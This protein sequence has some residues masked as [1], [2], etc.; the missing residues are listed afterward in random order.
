MADQLPSA[1]GFDG[2]PASSDAADRQDACARQRA[3]RQ[4]HFIGPPSRAQ[5]RHQFQG[6]VAQGQRPVGAVRTEQARQ[7]PAHQDAAQDVRPRLPQCAERGG[8]DLG[9]VCAPWYG[10][11]ELGYVAG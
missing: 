1:L 4:P 3:H 2:A 6:P 9:L 5:R 10:G 8:R 7:H 11:D